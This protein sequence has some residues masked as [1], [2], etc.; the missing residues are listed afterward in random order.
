MAAVFGPARATVNTP[1][2]GPAF[3]ALG[4]VAVMLTVV[5]TGGT[6]VLAMNTV[7]LLGTP[8]TFPAGAL[9]VRTT[10]N[11]GWMSASG[12]GVSLISEEAAP[13]ASVTLPGRLTQSM[14]LAAVPVIV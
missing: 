6:L 1:L 8:S 14:P 7:A 9:M 13:A 11:V 5:G 3:E 2:T 12:M 10:V 4:W